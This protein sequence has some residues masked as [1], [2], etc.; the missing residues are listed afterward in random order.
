ML[1]PEVMMLIPEVM[2]RAPEVITMR[3]PEVITMRAPEVITMR[4]LQQQH[5]QQHVSSRSLISDDGHCVMKMSL[6]LNVDG[7]IQATNLVDAV[8]SATLR[9]LKLPNVVR[10]HD[11]TTVLQNTAVVVTMERGIKDL[12]QF[13]SESDFDVRTRVMRQMLVG[14]ASGAC[15][16]HDNGIAHGSI[17]SSHV[18]VMEPFGVKLIDFSSVRFLPP[19]TTDED[20][21]EDA[22]AEDAYAIG[23]LLY[24]YVYRKPL[25]TNSTQRDEFERSGG[26][27]ERLRLLEDGTE[28]E[29]EADM[30]F[31]MCRHLLTRLLHPTPKQRMSVRDLLTTLLHGGGVSRRSPSVPVIDPQQPFSHLAI[32]LVRNSLSHFSTYMQQQL[33]LQNMNAHHVEA[34]MVLVQALVH[35]QPCTIPMQTAIVLMQVLAATAVDLCG[36]MKCDGVV[37]TGEKS[38]I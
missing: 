31:S 3:A 19:S 6:V 17:Q 13:I 20:D 2:M 38:R 28:T 10:V 30:S 15:A 35:R 4:A 22:R 37:Y 18:I 9:R 1:I 7:E 33:Q 5:V 16:L 27:V 14:V 23:S 11:V 24:H 32:A 25:F 29:A 26:I 21:V 36:M 8:V 12:S 34:C